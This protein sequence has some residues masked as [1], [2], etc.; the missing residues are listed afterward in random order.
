M[1]DWEYYIN[2]YKDLQLANITTKELA[3]A[4]WIKY[5][6]KEGRICN[7]INTTFI[8]L[9]YS[10]ENISNFIHPNIIP[11]QL[12]PSSIYFESNGFNL[13]DIN[14]IPQNATRIG[15]ITPSFFKK[16]NVSHIKDVYS[17][18]NFINNSNEL[19]IKF[20]AFYFSNSD[21]T[22]NYSCTSA[23]GPNF[24]IIWNWL[25]DQMG[26]SKY[27]D[28][29]IKSFYSNLWVSY[30]NI[31]IEY[32]I[33]ARKAMNILDNCKDEYIYNLLHSNSNYPGKLNKKQ[34]NKICNKPYYTFHPFIMERL[35]C[36]FIFIKQNP[37]TS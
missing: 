8:Y 23:H 28:C 15:F 13:I 26:Y 1:F 22:F 35:I 20:F 4:H 9:L 17:L 5:G 27:I 34:L 10:Y 12:K 31:T 19:I 18:F 7:N 11:L 32:I 30:T 16:V 25:L 2:R 3:L 21:E 29:N 24:L 36:L 37:I 6:K 33:F 14:S